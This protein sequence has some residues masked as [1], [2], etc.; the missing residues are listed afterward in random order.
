MNI[1]SD[2]I[3]GP[4]PESPVYS[5]MH[6]QSQEHPGAQFSSGLFAAPGQIPLLPVP[7]YGHVREETTRSDTLSP[8]TL[9]YV[10][11][12]V[13]QPP[14]HMPAAP[15]HYPESDQIYW[16][17]VFV[18]LGFGPGAGPEMNNNSSND[19]EPY[20]LNPSYAMATTGFY[21]HG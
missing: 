2:I 17:R 12:H 19:E 11:V 9:P 8:S 5:P 15:M 6:S 18:E 16:K 4:P 14:G 13:G 21:S 3:S 1:E 10:P 20:P 7:S